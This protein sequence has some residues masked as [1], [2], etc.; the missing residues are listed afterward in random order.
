MSA[1]LDQ[2]R[3]AIR[4]RHFSRRTE[5]AYVGWA[6]RYIRFHGT[7]HPAEM[8]AREVAAFLSHLAVHGNVAA[9]TQN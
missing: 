9:S 7:R 5:E 2:L 3:A 8:G 1:L 4:V 6:Y